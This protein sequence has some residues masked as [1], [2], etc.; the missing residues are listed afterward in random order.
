MSPAELP[1]LMPLSHEYLP[2]SV[3][4]MPGLEHSCR[5]GPPTLTP[6]Q[7]SAS[8][9][10]VEPLLM[11][12]C[13]CPPPPPLAVPHIRTDYAFSVSVGH[14]SVDPNGSAIPGLLVVTSTVSE[15]VFTETGTIVP[16]Y[17]IELFVYFWDSTVRP[18]PSLVAEW[19]PL[20]QRRGG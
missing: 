20:L 6:L 10:G 16:A 2:C 8:W 9:N 7:L 13:Y 4:R 14:D 15:T 12:L 11:I 5:P 19:W 17:P 1:G 18:L 3:L